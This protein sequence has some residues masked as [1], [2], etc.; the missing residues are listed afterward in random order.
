MLIMVQKNETKAV[1][2]ILHNLQDCKEAIPNIS[3][4][5]N[6]VEKKETIL[7]RRNGGK[8]MW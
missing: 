8:Q 1:M 5:A 3:V 2:V 4:N 7:S 6:F